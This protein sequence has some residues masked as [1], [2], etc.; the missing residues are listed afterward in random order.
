MFCVSALFDDI[1]APYTQG[2]QYFLSETAGEITATRP[3]TLASLRQL[4]GFGVSTTLLRVDIKP[5]SEVHQWIPTQSSAVTTEATTALDSGNFAGPTA[6]ADG[7][8]WYVVTNVPQNCVGLEFA[9]VWG[10][11]EVVTG[12]TDVT[13]TVSGATDG[14]QWDATTEDA[15]LTT[16]VITGAVADE[17]QGS[18]LTTGLDAAGIIQP[19]NLVGIKMVYDGGQTDIVINFG[20]EIV[21]L[22]V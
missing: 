17:I 19:D 8:I 12:A 2:D 21:Y 14:E 10:A 13:V 3:T 20:V 6:N 15:T 22:V 5:V 4:V 9:R 16:L 7:E 1:D 18:T 11:G